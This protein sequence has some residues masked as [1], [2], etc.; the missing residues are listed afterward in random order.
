PTGDPARHR[1]AL[2][3]VCLAVDRGR[4]RADRTES[5]SSES[6]RCQAAGGCA[7]I[8]PLRVRHRWLV[9]ALFLLLALAAVLALTHPAPSPRV[10]TLPAII[11]GAA[12]PAA[13]R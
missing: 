11:A 6:A 1:R 9:P 13:T 2:A 3:G 10:D 5:P 8:R 12:Q 4:P 7:M